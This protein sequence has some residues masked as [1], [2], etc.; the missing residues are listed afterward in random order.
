M[1]R[2]RLPRIARGFAV[3]G[4]ALSG[5]SAGCAVRTYPPTVGGYATVYTETV[6]DNIYAYPHVWYDGGYAYLVGSSWY[7]PSGG[8]WVLLRQEPPELYRYRS[9]YVQQAPPAYGD[10]GRGYSY[11]NRQPAPYAY[12]PPAVRVR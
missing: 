8:R 4:M 7:Y 6:P 9:N 11:P 10:P 3:L 12:P 2:A 5:M 1:R